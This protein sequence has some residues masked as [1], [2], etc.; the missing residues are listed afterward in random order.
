MNTLSHKNENLSKK[1]DNTDAITNAAYSIAV[2][3][4][5]KAIITFSV[6]GKT[7]MRM[8]RERS[9]VQVISLS[10]NIKT[11]RKMQMYWGI[12]SCHTE[13]ANSAK[14]MVE[15]ACSVVKEK[16]IAQHDDNVVITAGIP[17][18][19]AGST[20]LLRIARII[21]DKKIS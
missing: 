19:N 7:S 1:I 6:S 21:E 4:G 12:N 5:A 2:N 13:D 8:A 17:F 3:A 15:I 16:K 11:S 20:N 10:P 14:E 18:G 9:P